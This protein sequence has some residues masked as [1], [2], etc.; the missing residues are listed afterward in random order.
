MQVPAIKSSAK[1]SAKALLQRLGY[2]PV[3]FDKSTISDRV[4]S[5]ALALAGPINTVI[6]VGASNGS[7]SL[8]VVER[9]PGAHFL[10]FEA[11]PFHAPA[12]RAITQPRF[13]VEY[14]A[15]SDHTGEVKFY[16][17]PSNPNGGG[18]SATATDEH[19]ATVPCNTIDSAVASRGLPGP[20]LIKLDAQGHEREILAGAAST[21]A[22]ASLLWIETY[23][24]DQ[25]GRPPFDEI[26]TELRALGFRAAGIADVLTR[27]S[28]GMLW[29]MDIFFVRST[30]PAFENTFFWD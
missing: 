24:V 6:D 16:L 14:A 5:R 30:H 15:A 19:H 3:P 29:Q 10:L 17:D 23:G 22:N 26:C 9:L 8:D 18:A 13:S 20:Y 11:A 2:D 7:W 21:M 28:D 12:L 25:P 27:P 4:L 1:K